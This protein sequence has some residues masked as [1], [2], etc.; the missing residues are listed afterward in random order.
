MSAGAEAC[1]IGVGTVGILLDSFS[2]PEWT[3][4]SGAVRSEPFIGAA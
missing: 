3:G 1:A 2:F 4:F